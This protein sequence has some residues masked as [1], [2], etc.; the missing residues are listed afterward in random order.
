MSGGSG[1]SAELTE[2]GKFLVRL[3]VTTRSAR[4]QR[5]STRAT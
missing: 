1:V 4:K 2:A 5:S 3:G